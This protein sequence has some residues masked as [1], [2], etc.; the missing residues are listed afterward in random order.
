MLHGG[1]PETLATGREGV[2]AE[3]HRRGGCHT[4]RLP[5]LIRV[6]ATPQRRDRHRQRIFVG[7]GWRDD[8]ERAREDLRDTFRLDDGRTVRRGDEDRNTTGCIAATSVFDLKIESA[9]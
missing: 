5:S 8:G 7:I 4:G 6:L 1:Q 9:D 3:D 2:L